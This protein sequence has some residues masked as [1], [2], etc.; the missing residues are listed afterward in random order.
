MK[1]MR[2]L[3]KTK[4]K[5]KSKTSEI[6]TKDK[7]LLLAPNYPRL[8]VFCSGS[9]KAS[10]REGLR[11]GKEKGKEERGRREGKKRG[12]NTLSPMLMY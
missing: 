5:E 4:I 1:Q 9:L 12:G 8:I 3:S 6:D 7:S 10:S 2:K 11:E